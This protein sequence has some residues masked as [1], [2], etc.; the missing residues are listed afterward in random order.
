MIPRVNKNDPSLDRELARRA[1]DGDTAARRRLVDK[2]MPRVRSTVHYLAP[3]DS[4]ADDLVQLSFIEIL[5]SIALF[6]GDC[7]LETWASR[8]AVRTTISQLKERRRRLRWLDPRPEAD[9]EPVDERTPEGQSEQLQLRRHIKRLLERLP[10]AQRVV[11]VLRLVQ[12]MSLNEIAEITD[13]PLNTT[14]ERLR[15]G[16]K[17]FQRYLKQ[18]PVLRDWM[19]RRGI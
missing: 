2:L 8:I 1:A 15:V 18:D 13:A 4:D 14:R 3:G 9:L 19:K 17:G 12:G 6:R 7:R 11:I 10:V 5:R 16:R